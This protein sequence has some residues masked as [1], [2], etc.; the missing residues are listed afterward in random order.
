MTAVAA[1][2]S[3]AALD[4]VFPE[5]SPP[6]A[7]RIAEARAVAYLS[8]E[9]PRWRRE[10]PC[11]SCHNNGDATRALIVASAHG[12]PIGDAIDDTLAW[13]ATPERW[14]SNARRG[15]SEELPLARIQFA[16]ALTSLCGRRARQGRCPRQGG[17]AAHRPSAR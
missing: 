14:D 11:Y 3:V 9:V 17:R 6:A 12:H 5:Q 13:L 15:G 16:G 2:M 7:A 8:V 1:A 4:A 10:H